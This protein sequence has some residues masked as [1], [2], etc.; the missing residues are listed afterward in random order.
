VGRPTPLSIRTG[1][2]FRQ[3]SLNDEKQVLICSFFVRLLIQVY[4]AYYGLEVLLAREQ[5]A[6]VHAGLTEYFL[7]LRYFC[8]AHA[9]K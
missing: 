3:V 4:L 6:V 9:L 2:I 1:N 8:C 7:A 5:L